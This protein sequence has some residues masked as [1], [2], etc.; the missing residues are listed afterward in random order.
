MLKLLRRNRAITQRHVL[1]PGC[2]TDGITVDLLKFP[3]EQLARRIA[4]DLS[5]TKGGIAA[6]QQ[7]FHAEWRP[8]TPLSEVSESKIVE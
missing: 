8:Q 1:I 2:P 3:Y 5:Q 4:L 6:R 7:V